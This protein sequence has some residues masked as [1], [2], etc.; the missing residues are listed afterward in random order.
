MGETIESQTTSTS[1]YSFQSKGWRGPNHI[2]GVTVDDMSM[3]VTGSVGDL[4]PDLTSVR[5]RSFDMVLSPLGVEVDASGAESITYEFASG[6]RNIASSFKSFFPD[7]PGKPVK[8]GD[9]WPSNYNIDE[10][11]GTKDL[12]M[13]FQSINTLE[14]FETVDGMECARITSKITGKISGSEKHPAHDMLFTGT[15]KGTE[16]WSFG[17][18]EGIYVRST[19]EIVIE[20]ITS[21]SGVQATTIPSTQTKKSEIRLTDREMSIASIRIDKAASAELKL[22]GRPASTSPVKT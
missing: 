17:F 13:E 9:S 12:R 2:L 4:S 14:G 21:V 11:S 22:S 1:A 16:V 18:K 7:L 5:G 8:V 19:S 6:P 3:N 10:K 20:M 15:H